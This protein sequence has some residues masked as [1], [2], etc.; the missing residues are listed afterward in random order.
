[1]ILKKKLTVIT[2]A[3]IE[4]LIDSIV[5]K[6]LDKIMSNVRPRPDFKSVFLFYHSINVPELFVYSA[7][8]GYM[9]IEISR[10]PY[11]YD[12]STLIDT[13]KYVKVREGNEF[14]ISCMLPI[15]IYMS[16]QLAALSIKYDTIWQEIRDI[17]GLLFNNG[18]SGIITEYMLL[19]ESI[20]TKM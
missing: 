5:I 15:G 18:I 7:S 13:P 14:I 3:D 11:T 10:R 4:S 19:N 9:S 16:P 17:V 20:L 2:M 12:N 8:M 6:N 1:M